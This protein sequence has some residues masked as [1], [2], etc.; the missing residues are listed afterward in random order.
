MRIFLAAAAVA[1]ISVPAEAL[2]QPL[3]FFCRQTAETVVMV[4]DAGVATSAPLKMTEAKQ[5]R[6]VVHPEFTKTGQTEGAASILDDRGQRKERFEGSIVLGKAVDARGGAWRLDLRTKILR[7]IAPRE[8]RTARFMI[9]RCSDKAAT[10]SAPR[11]FT[12]R[13]EDGQK[14]V[15]I[16]REGEPATVEIEFGGKR[17][18]LPQ[19]RSASGARYADKGHVF[20]N[21]GNQ[22]MWTTPESETTCVTKP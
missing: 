19:T 11:R 2:A 6:V 10:V 20:W 21:K 3:N 12:F 1:A 15:A 18:I 16:F 4:D 9:F 8:G 14:I 5:S 22:A 17:R 7:I 13:C